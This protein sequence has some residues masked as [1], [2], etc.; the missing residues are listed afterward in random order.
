MANGEMLG[1]RAIGF[2]T[3]VLRKKPGLLKSENLEKSM[4]YEITRQN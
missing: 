4:T 2:A 1:S 3:L